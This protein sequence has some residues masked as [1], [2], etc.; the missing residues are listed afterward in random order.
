MAKSNAVKSK[1]NN[2]IYNANAMR[3]HYK[4]RKAKLFS[5]K[6]VKNEVFDT[7]K[8]PKSEAQIQLECLK[9]LREVQTNAKLTHGGTCAYYR[10]TA[11]SRGGTPD[12]IVCYRGLFIAVEFKSIKGKQSALQKLEAERIYN[13][14][15]FYL[16]CYD[17]QQIEDAF[18]E[19]DKWL[20][21][22]K[23]TAQQLKRPQFSD[24]NLS[25]EKD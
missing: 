23:T 18:I 24:S 12:C 11:S 9:Y 1:T 25:G 22:Y 13:S 8:K 21:L 6:K 3:L 19:I 16:L 17:K 5:G 4:V 10:I 7:P 20:D 15:G 2:S 14:S